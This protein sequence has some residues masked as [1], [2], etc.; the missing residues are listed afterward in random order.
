MKALRIIHTPSIYAQRLNLAA[1]TA[2][3]GDSGH[4]T[5]IFNAMNPISA[6]IKGVIHH[7]QADLSPIGLFLPVFQAF[8]ALNTQIYT[9][10]P[11]VSEQQAIYT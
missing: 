3:P 4:I 10:F 6:T 5:G 11:V 1:Y 2:I 7:R 8:S 9:G